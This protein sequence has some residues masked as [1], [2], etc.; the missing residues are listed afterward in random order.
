MSGIS[1]SRRSARALVAMMNDVFP[2]LK[3]TTELG[4][5]FED[6]KLPSL[7]TKIWVKDAYTILF[8]FFEKTMA[9]NLMVEAESAL[10]SEVKLSTLSEEITRRLR[11]TSLE[12][13]LSTRLE[14][15][16]RA[17]V[18]MKTSGH[19]E[20]FIRSAVTRGLESFR[21]KVRRSKLPETNPGFQPL[22]QNTGWKRN[23]KAKTKALKRGNWYKGGGN[24][25][26]GQ[27]AGKVKKM[28][29]KNEKKSMTPSTVIFVPSTRGG[30]LLKKL[31]ESEEQMCD[32]TGFK[33]K[34]QEA[35]GAKLI[36][37]F[38]KDLGK[39]KHCGRK[40]CPPCDTAGDKRQNCRSRNLIYESSCQTCNPS[41]LQ[42]VKTTTA[43]PR[44]GVYVGETSRSLHER[45]V[46]H[47]ND[48]VD[49]NP[50]S[51][52]VKHWMLSHPE[53]NSP[54][55]MSFKATSMYRDCLSRQIGEA[56]R[57][58][59]SR[60]T[61][62]N[63]KS[64]YLSNCITR[65]TVEEDVW[66]RRERSRREE[67][68]ERLEKLEVERFRK[69]KEQLSSQ[70][71]ECV[72]DI[73]NN[74][75]QDTPSQIEMV[76]SLK[77]ESSSQQEQYGHEISL[78]EE[79]PNQQDEQSSAGVQS[80][81]TINA[82]G[83]C[84][85][86]SINM[87]TSA[88]SQLDRTS[89]GENK[90]RTKPKHRLNRKP[91]HR[92]GYNLG[93]F[94]M[95]WSRME[96]EAK[97]ENLETIR[98]IEDMAGSTRLKK[99]LQK[100]TNIIRNPPIV[101]KSDKNVMSKAKVSSIVNNVVNECHLGSPII[102][103]QRALERVSILHG[104]DRGQK[105][106]TSGGNRVDSPSKRQRN[107]FENLLTF[108]G[109]RG[110]A[111]KSHTDRASCKNVLMKL[112]NATPQIGNNARIL[113]SDS[114]VNPKIAQVLTEEDFKVNDPNSRGAEGLEGNQ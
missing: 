24:D 55:K 28:F 30:L 73:S 6:G 7:D 65:I 68:D 3:F 78:E 53:M 91:R 5:D 80:P 23:F 60:D 2:F 54:P 4:E 13:E 27:K 37:S 106:T 86:T 105:R 56:L 41:S 39:G 92:G 1:A 98:M 100:E 99:M 83:N 26:S 57:I 97:K 71:V 112:K 96:R 79:V 12:T 107:D 14:I 45:A 63:S 40:P 17:C 111:N 94:S 31:K 95:W 48:A 102:T 114:S 29:Q 42:E 19:K 34:F 22:Y 50:K 36:N 20:S 38:E 58:H 87:L 74:I 110:V 93:Y 51:H 61:L 85:L 44:V 15:I 64:E 67:E 90:A 52:I 101:R 32:L 81:K 47:V 104:G 33:V 109:G 46:E 75:M 69:K 11:N 89:C 66:E 43:Q 16:E 18:K 88:S 8:E 84:P 77:D 59:H 72:Q 70:Q 25:G 108:W 35:G 82:S 21:E 113:V 103:H 76:S 9:S 62:L 49:F 10:S